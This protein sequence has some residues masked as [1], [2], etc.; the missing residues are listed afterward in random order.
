MMED[1]LG[2]PSPAARDDFH[3]TTTNGRNGDVTIRL[4][5]R[6]PRVRTVALRAEN[7]RIEQPSRTVQ[8]RAGMPAV[9]EW[10]ARRVV[11]D[12]PW[13][14]VAVPDGDLARRREVFEFVGSPQAGD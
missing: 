9:V 14:A 8:R 5:T 7:L 1:L 6:D 12:A 4:T 10:K 11:A 2:T 13:F 3:L